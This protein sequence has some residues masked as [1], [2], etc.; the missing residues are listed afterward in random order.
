MPRYKE[1]FASAIK[2]IASKLITFAVLSAGEG[3]TQLAAIHP[4]S[5]CWFKLTANAFITDLSQLASTPGRRAHYYEELAV[6]SPAVAESSTIFHVH[7]EG[8]PD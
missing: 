8:W 3:W 5:D 6:S 7:T 1:D 2:F 4:W